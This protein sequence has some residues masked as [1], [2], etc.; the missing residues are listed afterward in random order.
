MSADSTQATITTH[1][2]S[3]YKRGCRCEVCVAA[4]AAAQVKYRERRKRGE[5]PS[6][7]TQPAPPPRQD[8][9][10][11]ELA[12]AI[13][14]P[15]PE[16]GALCVGDHDLFDPPQDGEAAAAAAARHELAADICRACPEV[17]ACRAWVDSLP[18][19]R[20]PGGVVAGQTPEGGPPVTVPTPAK[21]ADIL[22]QR[23]LAPWDIGGPQ[24]VIRQL[25]AH[26]AVTGHVLDPGCGTGW[27]AIE[28]ARAGC[29][30]VGIDAA[31][32]AVARARRNARNAGAAAQFV[33]GDV[34]TKLCAYEGRFD[35]VVDSKFYD[36]LEDTAAR[37]RY[38]AAL[39]RATRPGAKLIV[40]GFGPGH[41]NGVHNHA[42]EVFDH[43]EVLTGTGWAITYVGATTYQLRSAGWE[44]QC[45]DCPRRLPDDLMHIPITEV[46]ARRRPVA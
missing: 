29:E 20:R 15:A 8:P 46:H 11:A 39:H 32:T 25:V 17:T 34:T 13:G 18:P 45:A 21:F 19:R 10:F 27:H 30:V 44:P 5:A 35:T 22:Y 3:G 42:L 6:Q 9:A 12:A 2:R 41:V 4:N 7:R 14:P 36:N 38:S 37:R 33:L 43:D 28:Y 26:G 23:D 24:S 1:G 16:P 31:L 40:F